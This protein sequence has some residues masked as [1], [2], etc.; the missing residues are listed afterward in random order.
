MLC[1]QFHK[2]V[3]KNALD[4]VQILEKLDGSGRTACGMLEALITS[5]R[6]RN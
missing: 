5:K 6:K 3:S 1:D 2:G 4:T